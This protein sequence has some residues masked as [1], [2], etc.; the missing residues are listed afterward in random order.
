[1]PPFSGLDHDV[2]YFSIIL[3]NKRHDAAGQW[4]YYYIY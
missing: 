3:G 4:L 1:M 2:I